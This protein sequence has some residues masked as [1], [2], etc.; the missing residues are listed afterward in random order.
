MGPGHHVMEGYS[1]VGAG[2]EGRGGCDGFFE[3]V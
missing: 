3:G 2:V 1:G